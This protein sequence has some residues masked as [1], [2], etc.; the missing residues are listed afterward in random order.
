MSIDCGSCA[1]FHSRV[2]QHYNVLLHR[3]GFSPVECSADRN[4]RECTLMYESSRCRLVFIRS[5]GAKSC[6]IGSL[7]TP[8]PG[9]TLLH[10][11]GEQGW[12][13][14]ITLIEWKSGKKLLT[15]R[16]IDEVH[17]GKRN[18]LAWEAQHVAQWAN[19]LFE[20]FAP[21]KSRQWQDDF[22]QFAHTGR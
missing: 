16:L 12:Y 10:T 19:Q 1:P 2:E 17:D 3:Y 21:G 11:R 4:G 9:N 5:D 7:E 18:Y 22:A 13:H 6:T 20:L 14:A 8:F 15:A